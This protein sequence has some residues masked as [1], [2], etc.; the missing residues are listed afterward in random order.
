MMPLYCLDNHRDPEQLEEMRRLER[1]GICLFCEPHLLVDPAQRVIHRTKWWSATPNRYPYRGTKF[2]LLLVP[3]PHVSDF[4]ELPDEALA[5]F[6]R[7]LLWIRRTFALEY[8][9]LGVRCGDCQNTGGTIQHLHVHV[10]VGNVEDPGHE[11]VRFKLSSRSSFRST[12]PQ[13]ASRLKIGE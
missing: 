2:H 13:N 3:A 7:A 11:P 9:G 10:I 8:Y 12:N 1:E 4:L 5:D 6:W